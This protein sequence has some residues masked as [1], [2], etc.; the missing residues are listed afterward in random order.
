MREA[1]NDPV[2]R[3]KFEKEMAERREWKRDYNEARKM[4][5]A[6]R[7]REKSS[8]ILAEKRREAEKT[9]QIREEKRKREAEEKETRMMERAMSA[10]LV[11]ETKEEKRSLR[12]KQLRN[13]NGQVVQLPDG[14]IKIMM[15]RPTRVCIPRW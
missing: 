8:L 6:E 3:A 14:K 4:E 13:R 11:K 9:R 10:Q 5:D 12:E 7:K 15:S 2:E 1:K